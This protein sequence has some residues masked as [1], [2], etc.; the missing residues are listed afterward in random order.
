[1]KYYIPLYSL[2]IL[3]ILAACSGQ[4]IQ[5]NVDPAPIVLS[6]SQAASLPPPSATP[7]QSSTPLPTAT[8]SPTPTATI[9]ASPTP[10]PAALVV[11]GDIAVCGLPG[12]DLTAKLIENIPGPIFTAGDN[13]GDE[14]SAAEY[15]R[16]FGPTWGRF[17][18]RIHP[19]MGNH[20]VMTD[21]GTPYYAYFG[22]AAGKPGE[23]W[24]SYDYADWHIVVLNSNCNDVAC[25]KNSAQ[26]N[27][28][29][30]DLEAHPA[31]C[32]L[33]V[34]HHPR[35]SSG[36]SGSDGRMSPAYRALHA[37]GA[38]VLISGH[39]HDYERFAP[40]DPEGKPDPAKGIRQFV[41][42]T[43]GS[44]LRPF[45]AILPQS[46]AHIALVNGILKLTLYPD[47]YSWQFLPVEGKTETDEGE[48][49]CH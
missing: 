29:V 19:A 8:A 45:A 44:E 21:A 42:G 6:T 18:D 24:Y 39:D 26:V 1:M 20:D 43:G 46:E 40:L 11:A 48:G 25:G 16:C 10:T 23:G 22:E 17:K 28:L 15:K 37:A 49:F 7:L 9:T 34:W 30:S 27:W 3:L 33:A 38:D 35:W 2:L 12:A 4:E 47:R 5:T 36:L 13:S 31:Q 41:V 32:T 14:G